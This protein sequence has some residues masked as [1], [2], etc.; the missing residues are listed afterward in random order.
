MRWELRRDELTRYARGFDPS[1][2]LL[3][4]SHWLWVTILTFA[5]W[6]P[7]NQY[8]M[9]VGPIVGIPDEWSAARARR[10]IPHEVA[11]HVRQFRW[12]GFFL[13]PWAGLPL[14]AL[15]YGVLFFPI[16][17]AYF[18]Y[19]L[20]RHAEAQSWRELLKSGDMHLDDVFERAE[21]FAVTVSSWAYLKPWPRA[22][23]A[24][25]LRKEADRIVNRYR[26]GRLW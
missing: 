21:D 9:T 15:F 3:P 26:L 1:A 17:L 7:V 2:I 8:A 4:H 12:F 5:P 6:I 14:M 10:A 19:R 16:G 11:G 23:I 20:E 25:G 13:H 18:R 22:L 24:R